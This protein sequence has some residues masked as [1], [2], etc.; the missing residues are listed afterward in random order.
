M[1]AQ[2]A[3]T[4]DR[5]VTSVL[6][7]ELPASAWMRTRYPGGTVA[8]QLADGATL[9]G[10]SSTSEVRVASRNDASPNLIGR[11]GNGAGQFSFIESLV[12]LA[13]GTAGVVDPGNQRLTV[14]DSRGRTRGI[15]TL[16]PPG[17]DIDGGQPQLRVRGQ[18]ADGRFLAWLAGPRVGA[19]R[20]EVKADSSLLVILDRNGR[21]QREG[22]WFRGPG[23]Y[24][25]RETTP[26]VV[27]ELPLRA[28]TVVAVGRSSYYLS[29]GA[30]HQV[31]EYH[32]DGTFVRT[33]GVLEAP[34][35]LD[36][37]TLERWKAA[38]IAAA[39]A[40]LRE[41]LAQALSW[42]SYPVRLPGYAALLL[43]D[44]G[45]LWAG[46]FAVPGDPVEWD[47]FS[48]TGR[49]VAQGRSPGGGT[50]Q[51]IAEGEAV[52][53]FEANDGVRFSRYRVQFTSPG[54][55]DG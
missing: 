20:S 42:V 30:E 31:A 9:L 37:R 12:A 35:A 23:F 52:I 5:A 4:S 29:T 21:V 7:V 43:D 54:A 1:L 49:L 25:Y 33:F 16:V 18:F 45:R 28:K 32:A 27:E 22:G 24:T 48:E 26:L 13:D 36:Q 8:A 53:A 51:F 17:G 34:R 46:R 39:P 38:R 3:E 6:F 44:A 19:V 47:V 55:E 40:V 2:A 11:R 41:A 10:T 50:I 14:I 15:V